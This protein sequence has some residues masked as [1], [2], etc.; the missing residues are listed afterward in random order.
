ML[1][2]VFQ[3]FL[4]R[5]QGRRPQPRRGAKSRD[6]TAAETLE[7]R[8]L[9]TINITTDTTWLTNADATLTDN[10][11]VSNGAKLT[12]ASGVSVTAAT[13]VSL[14]I[15]TNTSG[16]LIADNVTFQRNVVLDTKASASLTND[17]F[18]S[19][20]L[21]V[22]A[23]AVLPAFTSNDF[24]GSGTPLVVYPEF[25]PQIGPTNTFGLNSNIGLSNET[26]AHDTTWRAIPN[27][28]YL[29]QNNLT[30]NGGATLTINSGAT[31]VP[32]FSSTTL[33]I[34]SGTTG[35]LVA[36]H[37]TFQQNVEIDTKG[38]ASLS[39]NHFTS[40]T[41]TVDDGA[42]LPT[43]ATNDFHGSGTPLIVYPEFV[44]QIAPSNTFGLNSNLG[45]SADTITHDTIWRAIP[46]TTYFLLNN[47]TVNGG[48]TLTINS[49]ATVVPQFSSTSLT[50]GTGTSGAVIA[51]NVTFQ[52]NLVID[53][54]GVA[55]LTHDQFTAGTLTITA[56]A[57]L[58]SF[59][60]NVFHGAGTPLKVFPE[61]V[62]QIGPTNTFGL[63]SNIAI[64]SENITHDTT[65]R[66]IPNTTYF[67]L[68]NLTVNGGATLTIN[69]GAAIDPQFS[70]TSLAI[71]TGTAGRLVADGVT[72]E[73]NLVLD[74]KAT[75][76]LTNNHF[77]SGTMTVTPGAVLSAF[78]SND[79][80]GTGTA[81]TVYPEFVP[82]ISSTNTF[83]V[84]ASLGITADTIAHDTTWRSFPNVTYVLT[85]SGV[86]VNA[87]ATLTIGS[88]VVLTPQF[89]STTVTIGTTGSPGG[90]VTRGA[91]SSVKFLLAASSFGEIS[92]LTYSS[93]MT[94][95]GSSPVV[96]RDNNFSTAV[97]VATGDPTRT[98]DLSQNFYGTTD[99]ASI[100][101]NRITDKDDS[102]TRPQINVAG[103]IAPNTLS[104]TVWFDA[105][106]NG[107][108]ERGEQPVPNVT[109]T[110][111]DAGLDGTSGTGDDSTVGSTTSDANGRY[112]FTG[113]VA[114]KRY[115]VEFTPPSGKIFTQP[116]QT[117]DSSDS[118]PDVTT[119]RTDVTSA[120]FNGAFDPRW[121]AGLLNQI[122]T[123]P[124]I[125]VAT[126]GGTSLSD[127][128][129]TVDF[130]ISPQGANITRTL[131]ITNNGDANLVLQPAT[132]TGGT[133][134]QFVTNFSTNQIVAPGA[135]ANL[136]IRLTSST[137]GNF[138]SQL[139]IPN[140]DANETPFNLTLT[141]NID[142]VP[143]PE[144]VVRDGNGFNITDNTGEVDFGSTAF[145]VAV[146]RTVTV[147]NNGD[148]NLILQ[149]ATAST[150]FSIVSNFTVN[151]TLAPGASAS[152]TVQ[153]NATSSGNLSAVVA[154]N[155]NDADED[156]FNFTALGY[157][158]PVPAPEVS[159]REMNGLNIPD[160]IGF[161]Y[162][163][164][165]PLNTTVT[166]TIVVSNDGNAPLI[167]QPATVGAGYTI[168]TNFTAG[169]QVAPGTTANLVVRL[170]AAASGYSTATV[171]FDNNDSNEGHY[172][173]TVQ[174]FVEAAPGPEINVRESSGW[175]IPDNFGLSSFGATPIGVPV[176]KTYVVTNFGTADLILQ[177]ATVGTGYTIVTN[178]AANTTLAPG[179]SANIVVRFDAASL[180]TTSTTLA[181][182]SND[183]DEGN[184]DFTL[185]GY[186]EPTPAP[187][188]SVREFGGFGLQDGSS[189]LF[190]DTTLVGAPVTKTIVI[191]NLG[192]ANLVLQPATVGAGFSIAS[193]FTAGQIVAPGGSTS[194][195]VQLDAS[196]S[197]TYA[198]TLTF[199]N[200]DADEGSFDI[201]LNGVVQTAPTPSAHILLR[202]LNGPGI[203]NNIGAEDF[204][205][206]SLGSPTTR[207][208]VI[209]NTGNANLVLQPAVASSGFSI[210]SNFSSSTLA[211][212]ATAT[213]VL[214]LD[215]T[216]LGATT[217]TVTFDSNDPNQ[218]HFT[219]QVRGYVAPVPSPLV[220]IRGPD[221]SPIGNGSGVLEFGPTYIGTA[222]T[223]SIVITNTG[224]FDLIV[225]P[226]VVGAGYTIVNN[227]TINQVIVP[228]ASFT[229]VVEIDANVIG[230][231]SS[232]L[233]F[234]TNDPNAPQYT[235]N[236]Q[237]FVAPIPDSQA[238]VLDAQG[239]PIVSG[240]GLLTFIPTAFG[241]AV[242]QTIVINNVGNTD[243]ILQP[244]TVGAGF[245]ISS[246]FTLNQ[247]VAPGA[248]A[249][250][251]VVIDA[252]VS[253]NVSSVLSFNT[254]DS[255]QPT[256]T[257]TLTGYVAPPPTPLITLLDPLGNP[258]IS[259]TSVLNF[260]PTTQG[261]ST[262]QT[263]TIT[264]TGN[265]VLVLQ[266][267][268]VTAGFSIQT[269]FTVNQQLAP[270]ASITLIVVVNAS[271][272]GN[273]SGT[274]AFNT[275]D[276][277]NSHFEFA[278]HAFVAPPP[279]AVISIFDPSGN[280]IV[281]GT[282]TL[283]FGSTIVGSTVSQTITITNTGNSVLILQPA[284]V[285]A[286]FSIQTNFTVN[287][288]VLPG[289][290]VS[291]VVIINANV[292]GNIS[293]TLSF[294][295]NDAANPHI[296]FNLLGHVAPAPVAVVTVVDIHG[297]VVL[298]GTGIINL[299]TTVAGSNVSQS[300]VITNTGNTTLVL[301]PASVG[302]GFSITSN[303]TVNQQV[304]PG[305]TATLV[306]ALNANVTGD[307]AAN[308][309]FD[310]N[311][312]TAS[313][314]V[315]A[316]R[317]HVSPQ[318]VAQILVLDDSGLALSNHSSIVNF[319]AVSQLAVRT[320]QITISNT[321]TAALVLQP[322][323]ISGTGF[324]IT[325]NLTPNQ[326]VAPGASVTLIVSLDTSLPGAF[327]GTL[328]I[329]NS[330][331][332]AGPFV[333]TLD[334]N[335]SPIPAPAIS[336][337]VLNGPQINVTNATLNLGATTVGT[338]VTQTVV[339]INTG[340]ADLVLQ[341]AT[342]AGA[343]FTIITNFTTGQIV[344]AGSS[345][346]LVIR[347][348]AAVAGS[349]AGT[350]SFAN[351][352][353]ASPF[354]FSLAGNVTVNPIPK[355]AVAIQGGPALS[356]GSSGIAFDSTT[357]GTAVS[358]SIVV[359][360]TGTAP[361]V[362]QP[363]T[364]TGAGF[365]IVTNFN[366][367]QTVAV[368]A[369]ATLT[370]QLTAATA[371]SFNSTLSFTSNDATSSPF[372]VSLAG[373]VNQVPAS[374]ISVA[375]LNGPGLVDAAGVLNLGTTTIGAT[376][377]QTLVV[378]N[379]GTSS[380][381]L[382]P[383][384]IAGAGFTIVTNFSANQIL[385]PGA[386]ANLVVRLNA[387]TV[388]TAAA[389]LSFA[390]SDL[391]ESP[392]DITLTGQVNPLPAPALQVQD[393]SG[394]AIA[395]EEAVQF[396]LATAGESTT[397]TITITNIGTANLI[398]QPATFAGT[399]FTLTTNLAI[400]T[401]V[402]PGA[403][404]TLV[405]RMDATTT[406]HFGGTVSFITN[407]PA[408]NP[409][410]FSVAGD[411]AP[412]AAPHIVVRLAEDAVIPNQ[413]GNVSFGTT[414]PGA[415]ISRT[416]VITNAG[417]A[418]LI[419]QPAALSGN[420][421]AIVANTGVSQVL[422][423]GS[424]ANLV[425]Q[426]TATSLG[427]S[428]GGLSIS[429]NSPGSE[430]YQFSLQ[431][432]VTPVT[433]PA[434]TVHELSGP[435]IQ[436]G[437]STVEFGSPTVGDTVTKTIVVTNSGTA[438][439]IL[440][441]AQLT[442][443]G[444][445]LLTNFTTNQ[446]VAPGDSANLQVQLDAASVGTASAVLAF[447]DNTTDHPTFQFTLHG[448][449]QPLSVP[450]VSVSEKDGPTIADHGSTVDLGTTGK[451][452]LLT[453]VIVITNT[454]GADLTVQNAQL[455]GAAAALTIGSNVST[456]GGSR[457]L[458]PGE[459]TTI[460]LHL[461]S[462]KLVSVN[463]TLTFATSDPQHQQFSIH[464]TGQ[465]TKV[466]VHPPKQKEA[467]RP[468]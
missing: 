173:F 190:F 317:G 374:E 29:L 128:V 451:N 107:I 220:I 252:T 459:S 217:G 228:G 47:V 172:D 221:G 79:F 380:L 113:L 418:D 144:I 143:A 83:G 64:T 61:F 237:G 167:L 372:N 35:G 288:Q 96:I 114:N 28:V 146:Q 85:S 415:A 66:T 436:D 7:D 379:T 393:Q 430:T 188:I 268:T 51:D 211:P 399:G 151:Q 355:L 67:L 118:D 178:L 201:A 42:T 433:A 109:V 229:L 364:L 402:I 204:G 6:V 408:A 34:G 331:S 38:T 244:A 280:P 210:V 200:N 39:N 324:S 56:G 238:T 65:W 422:T 437:A 366:V 264:N 278:L 135:S 239:N 258:L 386:S 276:P 57:T 290:T 165:T 295:T 332:A 236:L 261:T 329:N 468:K 124:E 307:I 458:H 162:Y 40:G 136:V 149:P 26:I 263:I 24:H 334:G 161:L 466:K 304:A 44:P 462:K 293:S 231:V 342:V 305:A 55:T 104:G 435:E 80:H 357:I 58:P 327:Q 219:F 131:V 255:Q 272:S 359:T 330:D 139:N 249:V 100:E 452:K 367:N 311:D 120:W 89:A 444:F 192:N 160:G 62:P 240:T 391:D 111:K 398:L 286:G 185:S 446:T 310:T 2:S 373:Q 438:P 184:Y 281:S 427:N 99:V 335:V 308:L 194:L 242:S 78:T 205:L 230:S 18:I 75:A 9:L 147:T 339:V 314:F 251:V 396:G 275:N 365:V 214:Q 299:G 46:N 166:K 121:D 108:Q 409:F 41:L 270:G 454:G 82:Q 181:F 368:G 284:T 170:N 208:L 369:S 262:S 412:M 140:S 119:G 404:A 1:I 400:D 417:N 296:T 122:P 413:F 179:A 226:A 463:A 224:N 347:L 353:L 117:D 315:I 126:L 302:A 14:T 397:R 177:P 87:G 102:A 4:N 187:E 23:G 448:E 360:N 289:A 74:T 186:V 68:N 291:L 50:I 70:S 59:T 394:A 54:N 312:A 337:S 216:T 406:G 152:L 456:N 202:E 407:D 256:Y 105:N 426:L 169:Q 27:T 443:S 176:T 97:I 350:L 159:V 48:A 132:F 19:G 282:G 383:A 316:L 457:V 30:V 245:S 447:A 273:V 101:S 11:V 155:T 20:T 266:P 158:E 235:F 277:N 306:V 323:T 234:N 375:V 265:S 297:N 3:R 254:N 63:N 384:T 287:Q 98:L 88:G 198:T 465:V 72:F 189:T 356:S 222:A 411:V 110:L 37:V 326:S 340:N 86:T 10:V 193:N 5:L 129:S 421:F 390:N 362:L 358:K 77:T 279:A 233:S 425:I 174:G 354:T 441:S 370:I 363:A 387:S 225:Q 206:T 71:G 191:T 461:Q 22:T 53:T 371:G 320:R 294:N 43:F 460:V 91:I 283:G 175:N 134:Y 183:S 76:S 442:G 259:G 212:G 197:G 445:T 209:A 341:P 180:G 434:I 150:G 309:T 377:T 213:L 361:L 267:A 125:S 381:T 349:P 127:G 142:P 318:P 253:G 241:T 248:S 215:A 429:S 416:I 116:N 431:G 243:L 232:V 168:V 333:L 385:A 203:A 382:Q 403:T 439:L 138:T 410:E 260:T 84:N 31:I 440:Q 321:G 157:V 392:F 453:K 450:A 455:T 292:T 207:T 130:G 182:T 153:M 106:A 13:N 103:P 378:T 467:H 93:T 94:I 137:A 90:I 156:H 141:G 95:D 322:A 336:V 269:N 171:A 389:T 274:L 420:G 49:G 148:A 247:V 218:T 17:H 464:I 196:A 73:Q 325:T 303:F 319:G 423:P 195:L 60:N 154:F 112:A 344:H 223:Q 257:F 414:Q 405:I 8:T 145:G 424:S 348:D 298:P 32:Q 300:I 25:V 36:D 328:T 123:A 69:S 301:Q 338:A 271:I 351:N 163:G 401:V 81:L 346:N 313:H 395:T 345:A 52:Q 133:G 449:V 246:N 376:V 199:A 250:L 419:L 45:I 227:F 285:G 352:A 432:A 428:T 115:F 21:T 12:I 16:T 388:G 33:T 343:G 15:G 92:E 164:S